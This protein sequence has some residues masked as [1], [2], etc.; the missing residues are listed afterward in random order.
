MAGEAVGGFSADRGGG[1]RYGV[2][3]DAERLPEEGEVEVVVACRRG[4]G[5]TGLNTSVRQGRRLA[6]VGFATVRQGAADVGQPIAFAA[7]PPVGLAFADQVAGQVAPG[8]AER[9]R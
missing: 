2:A 4:P 6:E 3:L 1:L 7:E 5:R 9:R 8:K